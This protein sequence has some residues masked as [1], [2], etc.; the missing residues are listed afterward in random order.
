MYLHQE[1]LSEMTDNI[2]YIINNMRNYTPPPIRGGENA[3]KGGDNTYIREAFCREK[4]T[5]R[6][7]YEHSTKH[8]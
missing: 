2:L 3:M 7:N 8:Y 6:R 1:R 5:E 4:A